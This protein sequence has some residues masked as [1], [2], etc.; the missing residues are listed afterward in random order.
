MKRALSALT[1]AA[2]AGAL[3]TSGTTAASA[4]TVTNGVVHVFD[5]GDG[6]GVG[7]TVL[8]SGA[9]GDTGS[10]NSVD[11]NGTP[12]PSTNTEELLALVQGSFRLN[13]VGLS[14][15]IGAAFNGFQAN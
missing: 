6:F 15:K 10:A 12:D 4:G 7:G 5:Y 13:V 2:L 9:I 8:L 14:K 1:I 3:V 11:A